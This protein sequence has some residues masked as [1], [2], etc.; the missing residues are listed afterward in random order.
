MALTSRACTLLQVTSRYDNAHAVERIARAM[1]KGLLTLLRAN[2]IQ[3]CQVPQWAALNLDMCSADEI[4][5][6]GNKMLDNTEIFRSVHLARIGLGGMTCA[7]LRRRRSWRRDRDAAM[8]TTP[9]VAG[10]QHA[11]PACVS[12][13][14]AGGTPHN[15]GNTHTP[16]TA[17]AVPQ[18]VCRQEPPALLD[19]L[20]AARGQ[21]H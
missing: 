18:A 5:I 4:A 17:G 7:K 10:W 15:A 19:I 16:N 21:L 3:K 1:D 13:S 2:F 6:N 11:Y 9:G 12:A 8:S 20:P 14:K